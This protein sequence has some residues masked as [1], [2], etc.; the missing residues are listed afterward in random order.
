M[1][2]A[3]ASAQK[4]NWEARSAIEK[5]FPNQRVLQIA[6]LD[7]DTKDY[8]LSFPNHDQ[9]GIVC[10]HFINKVTL[11]CAAL[12]VNQQDKN[13]GAKKL[14]FFKDISAEPKSFQLVEDYSTE[15]RQTTNIF[16]LYMKKSEIEN[17]GKGPSKIQM[18]S[19]GV[20]R[21]A[22]EQSAMVFFNDNGTIKKVW[23]AD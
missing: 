16:L 17:R 23:T 13:N 10:G 14:V 6:D 19:D 5:N 4:D 21:V 7:S 20:Q 18:P 15:K 11:S 12:L 1:F 2:T 22:N 3:C 8:F 9:P